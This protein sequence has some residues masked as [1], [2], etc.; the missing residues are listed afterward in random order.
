M[1]ENRIQALYTDHIPTPV[2]AGF[3][4]AFVACPAPLFATFSPSH[5]SFVAEVYRRAQELVAAQ[6]QMP[7]RRRIPEFSRN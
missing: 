5:L 4:P 3:I 1:F 2:A 6:L 7:V